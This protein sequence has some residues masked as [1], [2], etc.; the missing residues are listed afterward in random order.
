MLRPALSL[1]AIAMI[2][3]SPAPALAGSKFDPSAN[4]LPA[5]QDGRIGQETVRRHVCPDLAVKI[6]THT[7]VDRRTGRS[8]P[9]LRVIVANV[10]NV[11]YVSGGNQQQVHLSLKNAG[12]GGGSNS[13]GSIPA[14]ARIA[15]GSYGGALRGVIAKARIE[16]DPD[17]RTD[18]NPANDDCLASNNR[19]VFRVE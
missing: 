10:S 6:E 8:Q 3:Q 19:T 11:D 16:F 18:G 2:I 12:Y 15:V 7:H 13:F 14:G 5:I 17:I 4:T 1:V 9:A